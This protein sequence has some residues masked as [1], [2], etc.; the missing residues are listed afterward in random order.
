MKHFVE[1][2]S[3]DQMREMIPEA[4]TGRNIVRDK[5]VLIRESDA[6]ASKKVLHQPF[7]V[8]E[9]RIIHILRGHATYQI[10]LIPYSL[11]EGDILLLPQGALTEIEA[12]DDA[13]ALEGIALSAELEGMDTG[14]Q[15]DLVLL[16]RGEIG[17]ERIRL[18]FQLLTLQMGREDYNEQA[19]G[20]LVASMWADLAEVGRRYAKQQSGQKHSR[21]EELFR[22]FI[23]LL[24]ESGS[25]RRVIAFYA[26]KLNVTPN[27]LSA[28]VREQS[29]HTVQDWISRSTI[30]EAKVLLRHTDLLIYEIAERMNFSDVT[31]FNRY[32]KQQTGITPGAYR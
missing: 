19:T 24:G 14:H 32:F 30:Q 29:G 11:Q 3:L 31:A 20:R 21:G 1:D 7:R 27:H 4:G 12:V 16:H 6:L 22:R 17:S 15:D 9:R 13:F 18:Y 28:V 26:E 2:I 8:N 23:K 10:N 5:M 25:P